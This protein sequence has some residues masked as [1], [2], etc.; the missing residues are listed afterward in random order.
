[1][2][3]A[4]YAAQHWVREGFQLVNICTSEGRCVLIQGGLENRFGTVYL[5]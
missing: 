3:W 2:P 5:N 1:M 4:T